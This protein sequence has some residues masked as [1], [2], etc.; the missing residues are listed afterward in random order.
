MVQ[1]KTLVAG[2]IST[3]TASYTITQAAANTGSVNN[4]LQVTASTPGNN[5]DVTDVSDDGDDT[6]GNTTNDPTVVLT[7]SD[8][9]IE[10]TKTNVV[11]DTNSN[12]K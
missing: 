8:S 7:S 11:V 1:L 2:E 3:Y 6:D 10:T 4:T 12:R 5:N 9:S